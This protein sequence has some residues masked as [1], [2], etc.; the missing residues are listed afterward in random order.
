MQ[1]WGRPPVWRTLKG[2]TAIPLARFVLGWS[3]F[4]AACAYGAEAPKAGGFLLKEGDLLAFCGDSITA[5]G[6]YPRYVEAYLR[7][8]A[9]VPGLRIMNVGRSGE[10]ARHFPPLM[11]GLLAAKPTVATICYGMNS[12]RSAKVLGEGSA[13]T[14]ASALRA[15]VEKLKAAGC[16]RIVVASPGCVDSTHFALAQSKPADPAAAEATNKNLALMGTAAEMVAREHQLIYCDIHHPMM[17]A[18]AKAKAKHGTAFAFAGGPGDGVHPGGAGHLV[19]AWALLKALGC[20]GAIGT[21]ALDLK[22]G[23]AEAGAGHAVLSAAAGQIDLE[24]TRYPFCFLGKP[25]DAK[26]PRSVSDLIAFNAELNR[27]I[28]KVS[29]AAGK[30]FTVTWG[31]ATAEFDGAALEQGVNLAEAFPENPFCAP[32]GKLL[33]S[34]EERATCER[35]L[36]MDHKG[37]AAMQARLDKALAG[38]VPAPVKHTIKVAEAGK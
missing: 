27:L 35:A 29:G 6:L 38:L 34:M 20:D 36:R 11:D 21:I 5:G 23:K 19:M 24:S 33:F 7:A 17:D 18:M 22:T 26:S 32:F 15:I 14:E 31:A 9:P 10:Q 2:G 4:F 1:A 28:L 3:L 37:S 16:T 30:R 13:Q 8:C 12:S 25:E